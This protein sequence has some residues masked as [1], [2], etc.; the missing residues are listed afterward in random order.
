MNAPTVTPGLPGGP[1]ELKQTL[2][3]PKGQ[4]WQAGR[5]S[6]VIGVLILAP[7]WYMF[8]VYGRVLNSRNE[9]TMGWLLLAALGIYL[10]LELLEYTR[11]RVLHRAGQVVSQRLTH[12]VFDASFTAYLRKQPGGSTQ[13]LADVKTV[14]DFVASPA[15]TGVMDLPSSLICLGL[16][17][18]MNI[19]VGTLGTVI[20]LL[21]VSLGWLQNKRSAKPHGQANG[22]ASAAQLNAAATLR[23]A[24]VIEAM[25]MQTP[26]Y[27]RWMKSQRQFLS[28]L[29]DASDS[30]GGI[31][32]VSKMLTQLQGT[33]LLGLACWMALGNTLNGGMAMVIVASILGGRVLTPVA[34]IVAQ[35]RQV[36]SVQGAYS[37]LDKLLAAVPLAE[38]PMALPPPQGTVTVEGLVLTPPGAAVPV[39]KN[40]S[41]LALP[42]ELLTIIGPS[43]AGK[44]TLARALIGVWPAQSGKVRL[45]SADIFAWPKSQLG[46]YMG[47]LPQGV[48]LFDGSVAEN[49]ARFGKVDMDLVREATDRVGVTAII[50]QLPEGFDTQIGDGGAVLSGGQRQRIGLA[51][52]IYGTPRFVVLDEPNASLDDAGERDL[53]A[54]L[55]TLKALK[56][57]LVAITHRSSL[58]V[59][60]DRLLLLQDGTVSHFGTRD[61]VLNDVRAAGEQAAKAQ[62]ARAA[63]LPAPVVPLAATPQGAPA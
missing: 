16:L 26:M 9:A 30:A 31:G 29:S 60:A 28:R 43:A 50:E 1:S 34:Q 6:L 5:L 14:S 40:V 3:F 53:L 7:S 13:S 37:R 4:Y 58:L 21:A 32:A 57:T 19:W 52:A 27:V 59:A 48:E 39:L 35:W 51:R 12:R 18:A 44:S 17:F 33:L 62:A 11:H 20:A 54:L 2:L 63:A 61:E 38:D 47:Y 22:A 55:Q 49:V 25:G 36:G 46:P 45:D 15:V 41:F 42:G 56:T 24:Q 23:N 10:V 8:E